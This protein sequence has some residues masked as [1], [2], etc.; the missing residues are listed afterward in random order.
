MDNISHFSQIHVSPGELDS[1]TP[2]VKSLMAEILNSIPKIQNVDKSRIELN[3]AVLLHHQ[4]GPTKYSSPELE[5]LI[6]SQAIGEMIKQLDSFNNDSNLNPPLTL[7]EKEEIEKTKKLLKDARSSFEII[8]SSPEQW[9]S[10]LEKKVLNLDKNN[11]F[12]VLGGYCNSEQ[13]EGHAVNYEIARNDNGT[14]T[15]KITNTGEGSS[16]HTTKGNKVFQLCYTNLSEKDLGLEFWME[17]PKLYNQS[18]DMSD[19]Y[20]HFDSHLLKKD[21]KIVGRL[22]K[23]QRCNIC[24]WKSLSTWVHGKFLSEKFSSRGQLLYDQFKYHIL[25]DKLKTLM[26]DDSLQNNIGKI[27]I[28]KQKSFI[29]KFNR[30]FGSKFSMETICRKENN[31]QILKTELENKLQKLDRKIR[32]N[33]SI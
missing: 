10:D 27:T 23:K 19:I 9:A 25:S 4:I 14:Y 22:M 8:K 26:T 7:E 12:L 20:K 33:I 1:N 18:K 15:F 2:K 3:E 17:L 28:K 21:N 32:R 24:A 5:G 31:L 29:S 16:F 11:S 13:S 6:Q 30:W